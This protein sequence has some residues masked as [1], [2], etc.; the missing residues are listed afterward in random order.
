[1]TVLVTARAGRILGAMCLCLPFAQAQAASADANWPSRP[2]EMIVP[3]APGGSTDSTARLLAQKLGIQ[4]HQ[5][6]IVENRDGAGGNIGAAFVARAAPDGYTLLMTTSTIATNVSLYKKL[7]F[8][9]KKDFVP[10]AQVTLIPNVLMVN[11]SVPA[12]NLQEFIAY[13]KTSKQPIHYG[14]AGNGTSQHL[15]GALF[16]NMVGGHMVHVPYRGGAPA[17]VDLM[18][19]QIQMVFSPLVEVLSYIESGRLRALAV[20]TAH[21][22]PRLPNVPTVAEALPGYEIELWN[23]LLAPAGTPPEIV[24]KISKAVH[25]ALEDPAMQKTLASQ[26]SKPVGNTPAEFKK[27]LASEIDKW[28]KLVEISGAS[29]E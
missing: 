4:L 7:P 14:S 12:K 29:I 24:D 3:L 2:I 22:S 27:N 9:L 26:G 19:G 18:A 17:N 28:H 20:T 15:S 25:A 5:T 13:V 8:D 10:I 11:D 16:N 21:R 23:G 1:M 6:V